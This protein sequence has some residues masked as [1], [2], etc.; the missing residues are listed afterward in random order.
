MSRYSRL[1]S[2]LHWSAPARLLPIVASM[3]LGSVSCGT[4]LAGPEPTGKPTTPALEPVAYDA[5]GSGKVMFSRIGAG[6]RVSAVYLIDAAAH[7]TSIVFATCTS[8]VFGPALS[9]T[10]D[11]VAW[12]RLTDF[13]SCYDVYVTDL[14][15]GNARQLSA[16]SCNSE[17]TPAWTPAGGAVVFL[18]DAGISTWGIFQRELAGNSPVALR[19]FTAG[20]DGNYPCPAVVRSLED[21]Q[22]TVSTLSGLAY[23]CNG[24]LYAAETPNDPLVSL[25]RP[26]GANTLVH[27]PT[28][29]PDG[30]AIAFLEVLRDPGFVIISTSLRVLALRS[31]TV[32]TLAVVPGSGRGEWSSANFF[33]VCWL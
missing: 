27:S 28:W 11:R 21:G 22:L 9:P 10:G 24:E 2:P 23:S 19:T 31:A 1:A 8:L 15:G 6:G 12:L 18:V 30:S 33:S 26:T 25:Y 16:F 4:D 3:V 20:P 7:R 13:Q 17:G 32:R 5:L 14:S 29:S